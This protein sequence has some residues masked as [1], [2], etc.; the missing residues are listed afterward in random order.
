MG[1][2][3]AK[4]V[5]DFM[6]LSRYFVTG[7]IIINLLAIVAMFYPGPAVGTDFVGGTEVEVELLK[8]VDAGDVRKAVEAAGFNAPD[9]VSLEAEK[10]KAGTPQFLIRVQDVT[11][12]T[13]AQAAEIRQK[14]CLQPEENEPALDPVACPGALQ[15]TEVNFSPGGDKVTARYAEKPCD[16][17]VEGAECKPREDI[18]KQLGTGVAGL[19]LRPGENN[20]V[21]QNPQDHKVEFKFKGKGEQIMDGL[22]S[23]LGNDTVPTSA[24]RIEWIS[25]KAG[26]ELRDAAIISVSISLVMIMLYIAF[27]FDIRFAPAAVF[28]LLHDVLVTLLWMVIFRREMTLSTVAALLTIVGYSVNDTVVIFDRIR[29][30]LGRFRNKTFPEVINIS[31]SETLGRTI[32]TS[33]ATMVSLVPF[34]F[35][36]TGAIRDFAFTMLVGMISGVYSTIYIASPV[37]E[38]I[39]RQFFSKSIR[40]KRRVRVKKKDPSAPSP[41]TV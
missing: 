11:S 39:D 30:N 41:A 19:D 25:G 1:W 18:K 40:K 36:G 38:F 2:F 12:I 22:R 3:D 31:I 37:T 14:L 10:A 29:E 8:P 9:V 17:N 4:R 24:R 28:A 26:K 21:V 16:S 5:Y 6:G 33:G 13:D 23:A 32:K 20:P 7:S 15:T 27:R 34:L 35:F